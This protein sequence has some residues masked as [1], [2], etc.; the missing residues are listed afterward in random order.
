MSKSL[1]VTLPRKLHQALK[2]KAIAEGQP[3]AEM[4]QDHLAK[5]VGMKT[6]LGRARKE[7]RRKRQE[8]HQRYRQ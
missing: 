4:V 6:A 3:L 7:R 2:A 5:L 1:T 8:R